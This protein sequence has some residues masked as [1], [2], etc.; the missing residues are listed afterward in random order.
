MSESSEDFSDLSPVL[1]FAIGINED[2][3]Q[4][5]KDADV[6]QVRKDVI[7]KSLKSSRSIHKSERHDTPFE[8][9]VSGLKRCLPFV[10]FSDTDWMIGMSEVNLG[11]HLRF[12]PTFEE[13]RSAGKGIAVFLRDFI[14]SSEVDAQSE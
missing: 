4:V 1:F 10:T 7:H 3:V 9:A 12:A 6:E 2:V 5:Y 13:V 8:G 14:E 11:I